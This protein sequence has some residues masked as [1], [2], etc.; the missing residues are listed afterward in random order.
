MPEQEPKQSQ[1]FLKNELS[2]IN[3]DLDEV[4]D[5]VER[6]S[7]SKPVLEIPSLHNPDP[8]LQADVR[9]Q[10]DFRPKSLYGHNRRTETKPISRF[11][12]PR[13]NADFQGCRN[14]YNVNIYRP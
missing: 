14:V 13:S 4:H 8:I 3:K 1:S 10:K 11:V 6:I 2:I 5:C 7:P 12:N 9:I